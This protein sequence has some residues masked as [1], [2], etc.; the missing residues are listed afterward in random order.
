[1]QNS[2][3]ITNNKYQFGY[4]R[5]KAMYD[6]KY[7][8]K[9]MLLSGYLVI[10]GFKQMFLLHPAMKNFNDLIHNDFFHFP[11]ICSAYQSI[12]K[13]SSEPLVAN[14]RFGTLGTFLAEV[15]QA[16]IS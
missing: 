2:A 4:S 14:L 8:L 11:I 13:P 3:E 9:C 15:C 10:T 7:I 5:G 6:A 16:Y 12:L 1:M